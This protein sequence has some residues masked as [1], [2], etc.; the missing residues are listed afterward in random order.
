MPFLDS[1]VQV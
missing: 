1:F